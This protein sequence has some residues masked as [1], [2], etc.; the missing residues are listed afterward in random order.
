M[1]AL[2]EPEFRRVD[3]GKLKVLVIFRT[4]SK[5][6]IIGGKVTEGQVEIGASIEAMRDGELVS[7]G[8]IAKLQ[9]GKQDVKSVD[10]GQECGIQYEG[11]PTVQAGDELVVYK[12]EKIVKK[13]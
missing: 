4:E 3:L 11:R 6:Q 7:E 5:E 13:I 8:K 12:E 9:A 2:V 1:Q 10:T